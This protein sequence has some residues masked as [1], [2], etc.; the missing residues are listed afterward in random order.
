MLWLYLAR[1][2]RKGVRIIGK[3][4]SPEE[5]TPVRVTDLTP[6]GFSATDKMQLEKLIFDNRFLWEAWVE[7]SV[8][9]FQLRTALKER[10][11]KNVPISGQPESKAGGDPNVS[12]LPKQQSMLR[13]A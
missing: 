2:D 6:L 12:K 10:G 5:Q 11:Y 4:N 13:R 7:S 8:D 3:L 9:Y 1:R